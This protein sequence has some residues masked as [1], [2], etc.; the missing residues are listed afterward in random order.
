MGSIIFGLRG[1]HTY[2][3]IT[4]KNKNVT[5]YKLSSGRQWRLPFFLSPGPVCSDPVG[6]TLSAS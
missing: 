2:V 5:P 1:L 6:L 4:N 3:K